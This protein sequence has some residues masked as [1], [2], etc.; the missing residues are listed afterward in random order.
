MEKLTERINK[1]ELFAVLV[2]RQQKKAPV[3]KFQEK[4]INFHTVGNE[5]VGL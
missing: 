5:N 2:K 3:T 4:E 1:E